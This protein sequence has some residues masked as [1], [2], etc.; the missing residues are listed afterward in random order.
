M[1]IAKLKRGLKEIAK[2]DTF[3]S[4]SK[5]ITETTEDLNSIYRLV[6][7]YPFA[8]EVK[9]RLSAV[10]TRFKQ[11][12]KMLSELK[13]Q[14]EEYLFFKKR[15]REK[16]RNISQKLSKLSSLI[17]LHELLIS[18]DDET[19]LTERLKMIANKSSFLEL[20]EKIERNQSAEE[21]EINYL[22]KNLSQIE[23]EL[24]TLIDLIE[25]KM[26]ELDKNV[27][28]EKKEI[29][30]L[31]EYVKKHEHLIKE[32]LEKEGLIYL[33]KKHHDE[34]FSENTNEIKELKKED[35][36][37]DLNRPKSRKEKK[38]RIS[39]KA[40]KK[41]SKKRDTK[42]KNAKKE[43]ISNETLNPIAQKIKQYEEL[44]MS[45]PDGAMKK[46]YLE[47]IEN[48]KKKL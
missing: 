11:M 12:S 3:E 33:L 29:D 4:L 16:I 47:K 13:R 38:S 35:K 25:K 27:K 2:D 42:K 5:Q 1:S 8:A 9:E 40:N 34:I 48:L 22:E 30:E 21:F 37:K 28:S 10:N 18:K 14:Q 31:K 19:N 6:I 39:G 7:D 43:K 17:T 24:D 45:L 26:N 20:L 23:S 44:V 41:L 32:I 36:K 46:F 15:T